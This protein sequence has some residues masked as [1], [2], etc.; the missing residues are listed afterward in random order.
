MAKKPTLHQTLDHP[1]RERERRSAFEPSQAA[2]ELELPLPES[3]ERFHAN[4]LTVLYDT[5]LSRQEERA[6]IRAARRDSLKRS[7]VADPAHPG[8]LTSPTIRQ[9]KAQ[10]IEDAAVNARNVLAERSAIAT[11]IAVRQ[12]R[13]KMLGMA[14]VAAAPIDDSA[15]AQGAPGVP[16]YKARRQARQA[17]QQAQARQA[18]RAQGAAEITRL[19]EELTELAEIDERLH[20][21]AILSTL[22]ARYA[23]QARFYLTRAFLLPKELR[24]LDPEPLSAQDLY[25]ALESG[26]TAQWVRVS[27][28]LA[29]M[30]A[31]GGVDEAA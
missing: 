7:F 29:A 17:R 28:D 16:A 23:F 26:R 30:A 6:L 10:T 14:E 27:S 5:G 2:A 4:V 1:R 15:G 12:Q 11:A 9:L 19:K 21:D 24:G 31:A 20:L 25:Q 8:C 13:L 22:A 3:Q 18:Q